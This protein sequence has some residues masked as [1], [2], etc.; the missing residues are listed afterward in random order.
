MCCVRPGP[1]VRPNAERAATRGRTEVCKSSSN[2]RVAPGWVLHGHFHGELGNC[3]RRPGSSW[4]AIGRSVVLGGNELAV[5]GQQR[6]RSDDTGQPLQSSSAKNLCSDRESATLVVGQLKPS[7]A[8][9]LAENSILLTQI[10]DQVLLPAA[11]PAGNSED[12]EVQHQGIHGTTVATVAVGEHW[13]P[14]RRENTA[15]LAGSRCVGFWHTTGIEKLGKQRGDLSVGIE[16]GD[17]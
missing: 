11:D 9:L 15:D 8:E 10:V 3:G 7:P 16:R 2:P 17:P 14:Q 6:I 12:E 4:P 13:P 1:R 5:P